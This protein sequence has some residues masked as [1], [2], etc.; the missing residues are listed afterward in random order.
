MSRLLRLRFVGGEWIIRDAV[1]EDEPC[2]AS[3]WLKSYAKGDDVQETGLRHASEN[4]HADEIRYWKIHQP[5][6]TGLLR[7]C[8]VRVAC[9][10]ERVSYADGEV[11]VIWAWAC[12]DANTV[13]WV[14]IKNDVARQ[15][16]GPELV[17]ALLGDRLEREQR[18]TFEL[19]DLRKLRMVPKQWRKDRG[20]LS[21]L[22]SLSVRMLDRDPLFA[23]VGGY[24][25]DVRRRE[26]EKAA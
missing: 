19:V 23:A 4:A 14:G 11:A 1:A 24:V 12:Y 22:R 18:T 17:E 6:V 10:P 20:W 13:H 21:A 7:T 3:M 8:T 25:L 26:W 16:F 5:I 2:C 15:G 9:H